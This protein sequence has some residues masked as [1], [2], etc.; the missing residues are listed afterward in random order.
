MEE[1]VAR[2]SL[3]IRKQMEPRGWTRALIEGTIRNPN[4]TGRTRDQRSAVKEKRDEPATAYFRSDGSYVI[5]NDRTKE[6]VQ[7]SDRNDPDWTPD[8]RIQID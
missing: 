7:I 1:P 8:S 3:K 6:I 5:R 2:C 4:Q